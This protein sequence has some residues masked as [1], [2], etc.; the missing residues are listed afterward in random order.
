MEENENIISEKT[1]EESPFAE[2]RRLFSFAL[3]KL[4]EQIAKNKELSIA[5]DELRQKFDNTIAQIGILDEKNARLTSENEQ[6]EN[7][8]NLLQSQ[9]TLLNEKNRILNDSV[10]ELQSVRDENFE[11]KS[12]IA[13]YDN[14][15]QD[16]EFIHSAMAEKNIALNEKEEQINNLKREISLKDSELLALKL[17]VKKIAIL[18]AE[19]DNARS[20][21]EALQDQYTT[22]E[23]KHNTTL[24]EL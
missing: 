21:Y 10:N 20:Q 4:R 8:F 23:G 7:D 11:L 9:M 6:L 17:Q 2:V 14:S 12:K 13:E 5:Q 18:E 3:D 1:V 15:K 19:S 22:I 16:I 24:E